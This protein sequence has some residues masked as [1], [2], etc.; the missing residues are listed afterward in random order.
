MRAVEDSTRP[1]PNREKDSLGKTRVVLCSR[2]AHDQNVLAR[3]AQWDQQGWP[4]SGR[5]VDKRK[6]RRAQW[7]SKPA[8]TLDWKNEQAWKDHW[9]GCART[10]RGLRRMERERAGAL[11]ARRTCTMKQCSF[12]A[13]SEG[14]P[15][16]SFSHTGENFQEIAWT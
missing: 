15:G 12:Y 7:R 8:A 2:S 13:R 16:Y 11:L 14:Q 4:R 9:Y 5:I 1:P 3:R 6:K 10:T